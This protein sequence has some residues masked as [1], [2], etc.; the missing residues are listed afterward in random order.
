MFNNNAHSLEKI[1]EIMKDHNAA[2]EKALVKAGYD[3]LVF[4]VSN[5]EDLS[6]ITCG[7]AILIY[8]YQKEWTVA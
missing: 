3:V 4:I 8:C 5:E 2:Y 1:S 6:R 7:N